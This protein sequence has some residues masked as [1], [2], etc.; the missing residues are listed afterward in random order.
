MIRRPPRSALFPYTTL[1]RSRSELVDHRVDGIF[2]LQ[3]FAFGFGGDLSSQ[4]A[5]R[6]GGGYIRKV[7]HL[8]G[9]GRCHRVF[10]IGKEHVRTPVKPIS[11]LPSFVSKK[12]S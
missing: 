10:E 12:K 8:I 6:N 2:Q 9:K 3:N 11:C 5:P 4:V 1:F 7:S